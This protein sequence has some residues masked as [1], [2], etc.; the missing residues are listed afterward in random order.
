V[1]PV[2]STFH[3][4]SNVQ[5]DESHLVNH[6]AQLQHCWSTRLRACSSSEKT[7]SMPEVGDVKHEQ[8]AQLEQLVNRVARLQQQRCEKSGQARIR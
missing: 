2:F 1:K 8:V 5:Q 4:D 3:Y 7:A 6:M